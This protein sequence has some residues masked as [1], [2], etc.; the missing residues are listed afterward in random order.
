MSGVLLKDG[1]LDT[2]THTRRSPCEDEGGGGCGA[3]EARIP[4][5]PSNHRMLARGLGRW[6]RDLRERWED[7]EGATT[8]GDEVVEG[9]KDDATSLIGVGN[10]SG[11]RDL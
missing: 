6:T 11:R 2:D 3:A 9:G 10:H 8:D 4:M 1:N 7:G 5:M